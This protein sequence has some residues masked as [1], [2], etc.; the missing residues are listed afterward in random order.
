MQH[1]FVKVAAGTPH[2]RVGNC[3]Y[4]A[5]WILEMIGRAAQEGVRV[6]T[7]PELCLTGYTCSDLFL[8]DALLDSAERALV[9]LAEKTRGRDMLIA[10]GAPLRYEGKLYNCAVVLHNGD[11]LGVVPK[12]HLP[13]YGGIL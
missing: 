7:L 4:N 6:L 5:A 3:A 11:I 10:L 12:T 2:I 1:G 9:E 13:N 8:H